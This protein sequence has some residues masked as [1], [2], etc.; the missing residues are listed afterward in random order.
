[1]AHCAV[2]RVEHSVLDRD[3]G[4]PLLHIDQNDVLVSGLEDEDSASL[5]F[6]LDR[7]LLGDRAADRFTE[8]IA[9][10]LDP[11][12]CNDIAGHPLHRTGLND[13]SV[14]AVHVDDQLSAMDAHLGAKILR[15]RIVKIDAQI[16]V[17][18]QNTEIS[19]SF[20]K[21]SVCILKIINSHDVLL[22]Q[23]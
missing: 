2:T 5:V 22:M 12:R 9:Y 10:A 23:I 20:G 3:P 7:G 6:G 19:H 1:M 16:L 17:I 18:F 21:M 8:E 15:L 11:A 14:S 13:C 4:S